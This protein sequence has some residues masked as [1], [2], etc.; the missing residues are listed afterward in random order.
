MGSAQIFVKILAWIAWNETYLFSLVNA[1]NYDCTYLQ[2][3]LLP[4][5]RW[6][7]R[8]PQSPHWSRWSGNR[9]RPR[10]QG[11]AAL[12]WIH[13]NVH[14]PRISIYAKKT[15]YRYPLCLKSKRQ[16]FF[17]KP[18]L[19]FITNLRLDSGAKK[20]RKIESGSRNNSSRI[21]NKCR[22]RLGSALKCS[23]FAQC[24]R[25]LTQL[26][27]HGIQISPGLALLA[28]KALN[29]GRFLSAD[30]GSGT[31]VHENIEIVPATASISS[32]KTLLVSLRKYH[33]DEHN[34]WARCSEKSEGSGCENF[35]R[36]NIFLPRNRSSFSETRHML[37]QAKCTLMPS[38][39][40]RGSYF[41]LYV[42]VSINF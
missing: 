32:Q 29:E 1:F 3:T 5:C 15:S 22:L 36:F 33:F 30:V 2:T 8:R 7:A 42:S 34:W 19:L 25:P 13:I 20:I 40:T 17:F 16:N 4:S 28:L 35:C 39:L 14:Q 21:H 6:W 27:L 26:Q 41:L 38:I 10:Q 12:A 11:M 23:E 24:L 31:A 9:T 37:L 18:G